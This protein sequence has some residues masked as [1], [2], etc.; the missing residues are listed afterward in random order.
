MKK[1]LSIRELKQKYVKQNIW[2]LM[3]LKKEGFIN[4]I[5]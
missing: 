3:L 1:R 5:E 4:H 2:I